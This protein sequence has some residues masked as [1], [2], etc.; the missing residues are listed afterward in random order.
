MADEN[1]TERAGGNAADM[2]TPKGPPGTAAGAQPK[3]APAGKS[4]GG[5]GRELTEEEKAWVRSLTPEQKARIRAMSSAEKKRLLAAAMQARQNAAAARASD[6]APPPQGPPGLIPTTMSSTRPRPPGA[7]P[8]APGPGAAQ[9]RGPGQAPGKGKGRPGG[10]SRQQQFQQQLP[11]GFQDPFAPITHK[12]KFGQLARHQK[13]IVA[14]CVTAVITIAA[15]LFGTDWVHIPGRD[16]GAVIRH[17][18]D[19]LGESITLPRKPIATTWQMIQRDDA[20]TTV[21]DAT[22]WRITAVMEFSYEDMAALVAEAKDKPPP[23]GDEIEAEHWFPDDVKA[24]MR[25]HPPRYID[26]SAF[27]GERYRQGSAIIV[28]GTNTIV[29]RLNS[30]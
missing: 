8:S 18:T 19:F 21:R 25:A 24:A 29:V 2:T 10:A 1:K 11:S 13:I 9:S 22:Q 23:A 12:P 26:P 20:S 3:A 5:I 6:P 27:F 17:N 16:L 28:T 15:I 30:D 14:I 4:G 7:G